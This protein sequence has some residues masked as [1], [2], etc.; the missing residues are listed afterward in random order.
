MENPTDDVLFGISFVNRYKPGI[1]HASRKLVLSHTQP[2]ATL[3]PPVHRSNVATAVGQLANKY[4]S[5]DV[6]FSV[7]KVA[8]Q[9]I[10]KPGIHSLLLMRSERS[11]FAISEPVSLDATCAKMTGTLGVANLS[12][13]HPFYIYNWLIRQGRRHIVQSKE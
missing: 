3:I 11:R 9:T 8:K 12:L 5:E 2:E 6:D 1:F 7:I 13:G 4:S 10:V